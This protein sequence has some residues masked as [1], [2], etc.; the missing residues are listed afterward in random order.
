VAPGTTIHALYAS[1]CPPAALPVAYA[2]NGLRVKAEELV[3][4]GDEIVFL[5]PVGG[6]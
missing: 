2:R 1:L 5:P 3:A 4:D 6:G